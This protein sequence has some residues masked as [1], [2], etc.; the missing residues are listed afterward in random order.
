M[1]GLGLGLNKIRK[2]GGAAP[3]EPIQATGG[4]VQDVTID[5]TTYRVHTFTSSDVLVV[6]Q[7]GEIEY[8]VAAGGG[9]GGVNR[10][11]GGGGGGLLEG[12]M[13]IPVGTHTV[14]VGSGGV[15]SNG[16]D[17][18]LLDITAKGGGQGG[19]RI[20]YDPISG[21]SGGGSQGLEGNSGADGIPGQGHKG[22]DSPID[23]ISGGGG[24][25]DGPGGDENGI[26]P[27]AGP[28]RTV[29]ISGNPLTL[30]AGGIGVERAQAPINEP[31]N[32]GNGGRGTHPSDEDTSQGGSGIIMLRYKI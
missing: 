5:D 1:L 19:S 31:P 9:S 11:G 17:S 12:L 20:Q 2:R 3:F 24:G 6:N 22:G 26:G 16:S 4:I 29:N 32:T 8:V 14:V 23:T 21:G 28:G 27:I 10:G 13:N 30:C 7:G 18:S 15:D 25:A